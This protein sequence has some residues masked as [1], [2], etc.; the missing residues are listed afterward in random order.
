MP[1]SSRK[2]AASMALP[3]PVKQADTDAPLK[4]CHSP[5]YINASVVSFRT[6]QVSEGRRWG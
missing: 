5:V 3:S 4:R 1:D 2:L 6:K